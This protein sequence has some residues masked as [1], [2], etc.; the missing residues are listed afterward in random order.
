MKKKNI[1]SL[2]VAFAFFALAATGLLLY[3]KQKA[4]VIEITHTIFGLIFVGFAIFHI[5]NNWSSIMS[6]SKE[7]QSGKL[8]KEWIVAAVVFVL[9]LVGTFTGLLEPI[10]EAGRIFAKQKPK[11]QRAEKISFEEIE[12][13]KNGQGSALNIILQKNKEVQLPVVAIWIE[14]STHQFIE[15]LFVP[16]K[17]ASINKEENE[18]RPQFQDFQATILPA[19]QSKTKDTKPNYEKETPNENFVL[20]TKTIAKAPYFVMLEIKSN[21][22]IEVYEAQIDA[23][24]NSIFK[25][26]SKDGTLITRGIIEF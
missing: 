9:V 13:N 17:T 16:A 26:K 19:W 25:L 7:R 2:S 15:N 12:T 21:D 22:K 24:G 11:E 18:G 3:I 10:A 5:L 1:I 6:Y 23:N 20:K 14:D 4:H 8:Q